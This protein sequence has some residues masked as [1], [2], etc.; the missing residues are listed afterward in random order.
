MDRHRRERQTVSGEDHD[1]YGPARTDSRESSVIE[2]ALNG[3]RDPSHT[4][5]RGFGDLPGA[6]ERNKKSSSKG[7]LGLGGGGKGK[8]D[9][10]ARMEAERD[11]RSSYDDDARPL[12]VPGVDDDDFLN[13]DT[14]LGT[15]NVGGGFKRPSRTQDPVREASDPLGADFLEQ[16]LHQGSTA[17][18]DRR[19]AGGLS[20]H[21][22]QAAAAKT[23]GVV[24]DDRLV[25]TSGTLDHRF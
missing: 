6:G 24:V 2:A 19:E 12:P 8:P 21:R 20:K 10:H 4:H 9:R 1:L 3:D 14:H 16:D 18:R 13:Q 22:Q 7:F 17:T 23:N 5:L 11:R 15:G 25:D